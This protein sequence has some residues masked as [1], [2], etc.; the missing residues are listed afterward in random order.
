METKSFHH[1][2]TKEYPTHP[3]HIQP[4]EAG[5]QLGPVPGLSVT[6]LGDTF[7]LH[8]AA[9]PFPS[10]SE[11]PRPL[12]HSAE[13]AALLLQGLQLLSSSRTS[14]GRKMRLPTPPSSQ[15]WT[16]CSTTETRWSG[17]SQPGEAEAQEGGRGRSPRRLPGAETE[18]PT[19]DLLP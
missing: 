2:H 9:A 10:A 1:F 16:L 18:L 8:L 17:R 15:R 4:A 6:E 7:P 14:W 13:P 3:T 19:G 12:G 11:P 5:V